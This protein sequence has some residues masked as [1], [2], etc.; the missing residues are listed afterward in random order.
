[1]PHLIDPN[2]RPA[3]EW[4]LVEITAA[5]RKYIRNLLAEEEEWERIEYVL[6]ILFYI[7]H[8]QKQP[9]DF[10]KVM[11]FL[12]QEL[13]DALKNYAYESVYNTLQILSSYYIV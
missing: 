6:Y 8:Q 11:A 5:D 7:L 4:N 9:D 2:P 13:K 10:S 3:F 1:M 12:I